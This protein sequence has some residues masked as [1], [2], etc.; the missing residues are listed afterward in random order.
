MLN[1]LLIS[2]CILFSR[3]AYFYLVLIMGFA[4][5]RFNV[6]RSKSLLIASFVFAW[7]PTIYYNY[8][9]EYIYDVDIDNGI[10]ALILA[11]SVIY[12]LKKKLWRKD[13]VFMVMEPILAV[14]FIYF[15]FTNTYLPVISQ[16]MNWIIIFISFQVVVL[17]GK[18]FY[19]YYNYRIEP[20]KLKDFKQFVI[21]LINV[22]ASVGFNDLRNLAYDYSVNQ[23]VSDSIVLEFDSLNTTM[24]DLV[25]PDNKLESKE[26]TFQEIFESDGKNRK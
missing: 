25:D 13:I 21:S 18:Y 4:L 12:N 19:A 11:I 1:L 9:S 8:T 22:D 6:N 15:A 26:T 17:A 7:L 10:L 16:F 24:Y 23:S 20:A 3:S 2:S 14:N 5:C